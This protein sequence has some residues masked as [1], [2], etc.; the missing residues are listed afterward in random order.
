MDLRLVADEVRV[1]VDTA[2]TS[3]GCEGRASTSLRSIE[4][5]RGDVEGL[6]TDDFVSLLEARQLQEVA[7]DRGHALGLPA[8]LGHR[9][10]QI[11]VERRILTQRL[12]IP[13]DHRQRRTQLVRGISHEVPTHGFEAHLARD[14]AHQ[15]E[16]LAIAVW[17]DLQG[18]VAVF[19]GRGPDDDW[20]GE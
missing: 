2:R 5:Q 1:G 8:H 16:L 9:P 19:A 15:Q 14:I 6:A 17:D 18:E 13:A 4:M 7:D 10:L 3:C 12:Q 11:T 20:V